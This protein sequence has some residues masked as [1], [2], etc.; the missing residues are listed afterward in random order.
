MAGEQGISPLREERLRRKLTLGQVAQRVGIGKPMLSL[1]ER[2]QRRA[3]TA[4]LALYAADALASTLNHLAQRQEAWRQQQREVK[5]ELT[6][7]V[8]KDVDPEV[9]RARCL[10]ALASLRGGGR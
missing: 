4:L 5:V 1:V 8:P 2:G 7:E 10:A 3:P 6:L 9:A